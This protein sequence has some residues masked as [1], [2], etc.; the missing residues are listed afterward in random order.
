MVFA[1]LKHLIKRQ[2]QDVLGS[3]GVV[4]LDGRCGR[5]RHHEAVVAHIRRMAKVNPNVIVGYTLHKGESYLRCHRISEFIPLEG[6][7]QPTSS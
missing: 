7:N 3:D 4:T 2:P 5:A 6:V 1:Q